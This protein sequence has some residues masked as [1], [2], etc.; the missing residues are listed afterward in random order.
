MTEPKPRRVL[1]GCAIAILGAALLFGTAK[2]AAQPSSP[3]PTLVD[4]LVLDKDGRPISGLSDTD[5]ELTKDGRQQEFTDLHAVESTAGPDGSPRRFIIVVNRRGAESM[6]LRRARSALNKFAS[7]QLSASDEAML[8]EVG[9]TLRILQEFAPGAG[10]LRENLKDLSPSPHEVFDDPRRADGGGIWDLLG[11]LGSE[12]RRL[13]GRKVVI[14]FSVDQSTNPRGPGSSS[15]WTFDQRSFQNALFAFNTAN[16]AVYS[17]DLADG[18]RGR[19]DPRYGGERQNDP[20]AVFDWYETRGARRDQDRFEGGLGALATATG[21]VYYRNPVG[22]ARLLAEISDQNRLW[23]R[24]TWSPT[25]TGATDSRGHRLAI[26]IPGR[27]DVE[28]VMRPVFFPSR[29]PP[30]ERPQ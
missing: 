20:L 4:F 28:V 19:Y 30:R 6:R 11:R 16:A 21:G 18:G 8:V 15:A 24:L 29:L 7:D 14:L 3:P 5:I 9:P 22:F 26:H 1:A 10:Q 17:V 23:Y 2:T 27:D 25:D 13:P 12:L